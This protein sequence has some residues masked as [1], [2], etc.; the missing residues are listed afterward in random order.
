[1]FQKLQTKACGNNRICNN[2]S[3]ESHLKKIKVMITICIVLN[4]IMIDMET[5]ASKLIAAEFRKIKN[6]IQETLSQ[7][8]NLFKILLGT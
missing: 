4:I 6:I 3:G 7:A 2:T 1:M 8:I 5:Q